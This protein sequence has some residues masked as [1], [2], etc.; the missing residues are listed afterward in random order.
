MNRLARSSWLV[1]I[2][3][4]FKYQMVCAQLPVI[5]VSNLSQNIIQATQSVLMVVHMV[6]ELLPL[7]E[8]VVNDTFSSDLNDLAGIVREA[9]GL[10]YDLASLNSQIAT[11]F[12]LNTAPR[13]S[14]D[15]AL[16]LAAMRRVVVD[17]YVYALRTQTLIRTALSTVQHLTRLVAAIQHFAGNMQANQTLTQLDSK[18]TQTLTQ[19]QV[20]TA[21][22]ERAQ[23]VDHLMEP[24]T[25]ES[26]HRINEAAMADYPQ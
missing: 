23:S 19:L 3:V 17:S 16:R 18:L 10:S 8:I 21:A 4:L 7:G 9:Q 22:Y 25:I 6:E 26:L 12:D 24:M 5:D 11:L 1:V 20:Q 13:T 2:L 14:R 15:L